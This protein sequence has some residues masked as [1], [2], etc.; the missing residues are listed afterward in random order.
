MNK[1]FVLITLALTLVLSLFTSCGSDETEEVSR[2]TEWPSDVFSFMADIPEY[3][4]EQYDVSIDYDNET[5]VIYYK[6]ATLS[7]TEGYIDTLERLGIER[8][9]CDSFINDGKYY[10]ISKPKEGKIFAEVIWY[11]TDYEDQN[12][13]KYEYA[14]VL[15]FAQY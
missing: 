8:L 13:K 3:N 1:Y 9:Y 12:G 7:R 14:L 5:V 6:E 4:G 11:D 2:E 15:K 10:W